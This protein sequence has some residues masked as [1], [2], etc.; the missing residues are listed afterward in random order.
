VKANN[1]TFHFT[2]NH[3]SS[4]SSS[5]LRSHG[6]LLQFACQTIIGKLLTTM[7]TMTDQHEDLPFQAVC[8]CAGGVEVCCFSN[9]SCLLRWHDDVS[10]LK[11]RIADS[12][13]H[14]EWNKFHCEKQASNAA[15][16]MHRRLLSKCN[17]MR[18]LV[19]GVQCSC[20]MR[21]V[22]RKSSS[23]GLALAVQKH[24]WML[25]T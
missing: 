9:S 14:H 23:I 6:C 5:I 13:R 18:L 3:T 16:C 4:Q 2:S 24:H 15:L 22:T 1:K 7:T 10:A 12:G 19:W 25:A 20:E 17:G 8:H 11:D 21:Q